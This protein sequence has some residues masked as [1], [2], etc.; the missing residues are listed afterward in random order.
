MI[1]KRKKI[2]R[3]KAKIKIQKKVQSNPAQ[4]FPQAVKTEINSFK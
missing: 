2:K 3:I 1:K 4:L